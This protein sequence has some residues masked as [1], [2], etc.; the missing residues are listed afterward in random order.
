M[1][2]IISIHL[3][4]FWYCTVTSLNKIK[5]L[6]IFGN[7]KSKANHTRQNMQFILHN[8]TVT[9]SLHISLLPVLL[10]E[11]RD[12]SLHTKLAGFNFQCNLASTF[13]TF[14]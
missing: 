11:Q 12:P 7:R 3:N 9:I 1:K 5:V 6:I 14:C 13:P 2:S 8:F 10:S 4:T